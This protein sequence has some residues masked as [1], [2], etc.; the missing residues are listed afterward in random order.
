MTVK[1]LL[2]GYQ[3]RLE[4]DRGVPFPWEWEAEFVDEMMC[5]RIVRGDWYFCWRVSYKLIIGN[6]EKKGKEKTK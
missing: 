6:K 5:L 2:E 1:L 4:W 3:F